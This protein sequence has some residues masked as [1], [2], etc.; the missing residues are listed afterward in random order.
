MQVLRNRSG[1]LLPVAA[2]W[3]QVSILCLH[4]R[5]VAGDYDGGQQTRHLDVTGGGASSAS[6]CFSLNRTSTAAG[7]A[8]EPT[9]P[10]VIRASA[11]R[12]VDGGK[13]RGSLCTCVNVNVRECAGG[14]AL[15]RWRCPM[16]RSKG[17]VQGF[18][19]Y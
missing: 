8:V 7:C 18:N 10:E 15:V 14:R 16:A 19:V 13:I 4:D 9:F 2:V 17:V 6:P 5:S 11:A 12:R 1:L 3:C